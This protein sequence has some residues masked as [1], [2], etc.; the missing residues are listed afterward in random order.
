MNLLSQVGN[1]KRDGNKTHTSF[2]CRKGGRK[3]WA[4]NKETT[5][6]LAFFLLKSAIKQSIFSEKVDM[7]FREYGIN[8][9]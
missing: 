8:K 2:F 9:K 1:I 5:P 4:K 6:S 7:R 3:M